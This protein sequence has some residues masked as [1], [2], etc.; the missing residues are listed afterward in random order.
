[1]LTVDVSCALKACKDATM[2]GDDASPMLVA[3]KRGRDDDDARFDCKEEL[4]DFDNDTAAHDPTREACFQLEGDEYVRYM[5]E[6][7]F[8]C[9]VDGSSEDLDH[10]KAEILETPSLSDLFE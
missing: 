9:P 6:G 10:G 4:S 3:R 2:L 1:M 8:F 5:F 7:R